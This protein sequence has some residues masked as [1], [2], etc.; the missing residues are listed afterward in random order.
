[1]PPSFPTR[2]LSVL[3]AAPH[4]SATVGLVVDHQILKPVL[5]EITPDRLSALKALVAA[6]ANADVEPSGIRRLAA[7]LPADSELAD[8]I[9]R[10]LKPHNAERKRLVSAAARQAISSEERSVGNESVRV[11]PGGRRI[12]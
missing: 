7:L 12:N 9:A 2:H 4:P 6:E 10:R 5:P 3:L 11:N 8:A 1:M